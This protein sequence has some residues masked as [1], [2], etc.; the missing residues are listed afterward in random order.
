MV[1]SGSLHVLA[2]YPHR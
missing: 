2:L 1:F